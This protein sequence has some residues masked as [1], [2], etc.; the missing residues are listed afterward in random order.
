[1]APG[2]PLHRLFQWKSRLQYAYILSIDT[3]Y[4]HTIAVVRLIIY[5]AHSAKRTSIIIA[6]TK[7]DAPNCLSAVGLPQLYVDQLRIMRG[8]IDN[9]VLVVVHKVITGPKFS[10]R[11]LQKKLDWKDWIAAEWIQLDNYAKQNMCGA[12]CTAPIDAPIIL[13]KMTERK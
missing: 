4:V 2:A 9:M 6:F 8:R 5:E 10:R 1:M 7:Y 12:P 11:T 13:T 3:M